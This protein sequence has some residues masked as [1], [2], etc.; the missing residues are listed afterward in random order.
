MRA[1][2]A[3]ESNLVRWYGSS[4]EELVSDA[5]LPEHSQRIRVLTS[6]TSHQKILC[7][8]I[9]YYDSSHDSSHRILPHYNG[10]CYNVGLRSFFGFWL[11]CL[12][13]LYLTT[14]PCRKDSNQYQPYTFALVAF[15]LNN[16]DIAYP[17]FIASSFII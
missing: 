7:F 8:Y 14:L 2:A 1:R 13:P 11:S 6:Q 15:E 17:N 12:S 4:A 3:A 16:L 5:Q 10:I 9:Y